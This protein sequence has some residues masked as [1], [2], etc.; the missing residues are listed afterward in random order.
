MNNEPKVSLYGIAAGPAAFSHPTAHDTAVCLASDRPCH[1]GRRRV[2]QPA[3]ARFLRDRAGGPGADQVR[4]DVYLSE[5]DCPDFL[6]ALNQRGWVAGRPAQPSGSAVRC[7]LG[8]WRRPEQGQVPAQPGLVAA[9]EAVMTT[10]GG[11]GVASARSIT[12]RWR[13]P[14]LLRTAPISNKLVQ[15]SVVSRNTCSTG[16]ARTDEPVNQ[17]LIKRPLQPAAQNPPN[18]TFMTDAPDDTSKPQLERQIQPTRTVFHSRRR[19]W[20]KQLAN[21]AAQGTGCQWLSAG[22][23]DATEK[24]C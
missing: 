1:A 23:P 13:G 16:R 11:Y 24:G 14:R 17:P 10:F 4:V 15:R 7:R 18:S 8:V 21:Q 22:T 20:P 19:L 3:S 2:V 9:A 5:Q 6:P 12:R